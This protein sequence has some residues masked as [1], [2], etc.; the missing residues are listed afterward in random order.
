MYRKPLLLIALTFSASFALTPSEPVQYRDTADHGF[1]KGWKNHER[2]AIYQ[3]FDIHTHFE[4]SAGSIKQIKS[5]AQ[6][7]IPELEEMDVSGCAVMGGPDSLLLYCKN[8]DEKKRFL[9]PF[10]WIDYNAPDTGKLIKLAASHMIKGV[11]LHNNR[12]YKAGADYKIMGAP[13]WDSIYE[14]CARYRLPVLWHLNQRYR[15]EKTGM[16]TGAFWSMLP[17]TNDDVLKHFIQIAKRHPK[18]NFILA[19]FNFLGYPRLGR[20]F[21]SL[22]NVSSDPSS[23]W[24][25][26]SDETIGPEQQKEAREFAIRYADRILFGTDFQFAAREKSNDPVWLRNCYRSHIR[27]LIQL[28]LPQ[29]V[30]D[31]ISYKNAKR[32]LSLE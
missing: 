29:D 24:L 2:P 1:S 30:L 25:I 13:V 9:Y 27:F 26:G 12:L 23:S 11:K 22:P 3:L 6:F 31:K 20:L 21:D 14:I 32:L 17:Y 18:T 10:L 8:Q 4:R 19:H 5:V 7:W 28:D 16:E 15:P